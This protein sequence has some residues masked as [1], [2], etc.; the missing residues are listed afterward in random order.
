MYLA[1]SWLDPEACVGVLAATG[2]EG[3]PMTDMEGLVAAGE[4]AAGTVEFAATVVEL[5]AALGIGTTDTVPPE[6]DP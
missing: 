6:I 3:A 1:P 4:A 2:F 5:A